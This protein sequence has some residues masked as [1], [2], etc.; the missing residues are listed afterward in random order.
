MSNE[1]FIIDAVRTPVG[2]RGGALATM[3]SA[4]LAAHSIAALMSRT[5]VDPGAVAPFA[6]LLVV[7]APIVRRTTDI[8]RKPRRTPPRFPP[9]AQSGGEFSPS[10]CGTRRPRLSACDETPST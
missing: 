3:H 5:G 9:G 2:K 6:H 8:G 4:D 10:P 7:H 1:A